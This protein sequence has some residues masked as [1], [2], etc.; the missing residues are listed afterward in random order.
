M[1]VALKRMRFG[2]AHLGPGDEVPVE[3]G[4]NYNLLL[5]QGLIADLDAVTADEEAHTRQVAGHKARETVLENELDAA[6]EEI[7]RLRAEIAAGTADGA[8][9]EQGSDDA[10]VAP[11]GSEENPLVV[12]LEELKKDDL[13]EVAKERGVEVTSRMNKDD[14]LAAL[15]NAESK[16]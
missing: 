11:A 16:E 10:D 5:R 13:L 6:H 8:D 14:I 9:A 12:N 2:E 15:T 3:P 1:Y 4:R 7:A